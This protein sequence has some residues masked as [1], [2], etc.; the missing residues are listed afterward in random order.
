M[1]WVLLR[2]QAIEYFH[3]IHFWQHQIQQNEI[4]PAA[5]RGPKAFVTSC[6][7]VNEIPS[8][9]E[10]LADGIAQRRVVLDEQQAHGFAQTGWIKSFLQV[11]EKVYFSDH[12][13]GMPNLT[14]FIHPLPPNYALTRDPFNVLIW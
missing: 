12:S 8:L 13:K 7:S 11:W 14:S 3:A 4:I 1:Q 10:V 2:T 5:F 9:T 6:C